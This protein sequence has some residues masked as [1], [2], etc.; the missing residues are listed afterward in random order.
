M[1]YPMMPPRPLIFSP[2]FASPPPPKP[3]P[4][5]M[6]QAYQP[7]PRPG[8]SISTIYPPPPP[9]RP[10]IENTVIAPVMR[11]PAPVK[12]GAPVVRDLQKELLNFV[13]PSLLR[14]RNA[15]GRTVNLTP[16]VEEGGKDEGETRADAPQVQ[17]PS[18]KT[19]TPSSLD[20]D[21]DKFLK[22]MDGLL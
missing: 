19:N 10:L 2:N 14:K 21:Y 5:F 3:P 16:H 4:Q 8:P 20:H 13:P 9:Q 1:P 11:F 22:E 17:L 18:K 15:P 12:S 7:Q 6:H